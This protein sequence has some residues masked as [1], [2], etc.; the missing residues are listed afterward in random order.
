MRR[1]AIDALGTLGGERAIVHLTRLLADEDARMGQAALEALLRIEDAGA[2][3][4]T[5]LLE[6]TATDERARQW[7]AIGLG[8]RGDARAFAPLLAILQSDEP[9][10]RGAAATAL[11]ALDDP[12]AAVPLIALLNN[13]DEQA[14]V[15]CRAA[16]ALARRHDRGAVPA[17]SAALRGGSRVV[18]VCVAAALGQFDDERAVAA[19]AAASQDD[20]WYV[21]HRAT[22]S[23]EEIRRRRGG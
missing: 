2:S 5:P 4:L 17:L 13:V 21:R 16:T 10:M 15:R 18:R 6:D 9:L 14:G 19:L 23:I 1:R 20:D 7:A 8:R 12:R 3:V 11:A 22:S